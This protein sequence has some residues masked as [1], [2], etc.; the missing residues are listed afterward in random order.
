MTE[1]E[2]VN[3]QQQLIARLLY[4]RDS[5][6]EKIPKR[7]IHSIDKKNNYKV[8]TV[9]FVGLAA[10]LEKAMRSGVINKSEVRAKVNEF[11]DWYKNEFG[12]RGNVRN[13]REDIE[14]GNKIINEVLEDLSNE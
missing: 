1:T 8:R 7:I 14:R 10:D 6:S 12:L 11:F 13:T 3:P 2:T 5:F 9:W 4:F